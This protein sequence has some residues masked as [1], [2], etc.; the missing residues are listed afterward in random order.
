MSVHLN[1]SMLEMFLVN[2]QM[3]AAPFDGS[4]HC[5]FLIPIS[6][7]RLLQY[8]NK[9]SLHLDVLV[10]LLMSFVGVL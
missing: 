1:V 2:L 10:C 5:F 4:L 6:L 9:K 3:S 8:W 7:L